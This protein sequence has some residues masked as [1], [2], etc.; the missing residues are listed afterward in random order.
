MTS[1]TGAPQGRLWFN[2][3]GDRKKET[4]VITLWP[5]RSLSLKGFRIFMASL[6]SLM[7]LIADRILSFGCL[8]CYR[9][10]GGRKS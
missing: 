4:Y 9:V 2:R 3:Q 7:S 6:A 8:A 1:Q 5:Y 10:F